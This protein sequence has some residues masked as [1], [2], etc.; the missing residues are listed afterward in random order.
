MFW[1]AS[2]VVMMII[3]IFYP[4]QFPVAIWQLA[5]QEVFV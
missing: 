5:L 4:G 2:A 3:A 1:L